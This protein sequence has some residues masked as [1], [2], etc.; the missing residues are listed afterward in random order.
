[1][2]YKSLLPFLTAAAGAGAGYFFFGRAKPGQKV[3]KPAM[4]VWATAIGG[5]LVG[6]A[7]GQF[8]RGRLQQA[9]ALPQAASPKPAPADD[10]VDL[11]APLALPEHQSDS[12]DVR[13]T[14]ADD[15]A[16]MDS[17]GSLA[18][19]GEDGLGS[20]EQ[21]VDVDDID[22]GELMREAGYN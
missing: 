8:V 18:G 5:A 6:Y 13:A 11:D 10:T 2:D 20:Y 16:I 14:D 15:A 3:A 1:M 22:V 7:A 19:S 17:M 21:D 12:V 9:P 4:E